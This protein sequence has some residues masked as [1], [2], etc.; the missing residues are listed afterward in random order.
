MTKGELIKI[1]ADKAGIPNRTATLAFEAITDEITKALSKG[2]RVALVRFGSFSV[3]KRAARMGRNPLTK[4]EIRI[5]TKK[6]PRFKP[7]REL[8]KRVSRK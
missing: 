2:K 6:V 5:P 7:S 4:Q 1:V 3:S 8:K